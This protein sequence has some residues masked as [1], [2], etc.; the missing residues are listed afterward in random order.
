M[1]QVQNKKAPSA[2]SPA[3][4]EGVAGR[5]L[6][7][8]PDPYSLV[9]SEGKMKG[10]KTAHTQKSSILYLLHLLMMTLRGP[11][12]EALSQCLFKGSLS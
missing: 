3:L 7:L 9:E 11:S 4:L 12:I 8:D 5:E 2:V 10:P 1:E 6:F